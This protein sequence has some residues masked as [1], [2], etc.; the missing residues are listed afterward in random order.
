MAMTAYG[1][2]CTQFYDL[3]KPQAPELA[4]EW[5]SQRLQGAGRVLEP[6]CGS[7]RF[8]VPLVSRGL[9]VD[10]VDPSEPML[11]ACRAKAASA[12]IAVV[13][14]WGTWDPSSAE[15]WPD[16]NYPQPPRIR[17]WQ[18]ALEHL[19]LAGPAPVPASPDAVPPAREAVEPYGAAFIPSS[20]FCLL[21]NA[22]AH[23]GL[24]RL[25]AHL[26]ARA[27]LLIEFEVPHG[28]DHWPGGNSR[29]VTAGSRQIRLVSRVE[30]NAG[31]QVET[32]YNQYELKES[33][34]VVQTENEVLR[35]RSYAPDE[36]RLLLAGAGFTEIEVEH[37]EF[38]WVV[39]ANAG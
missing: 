8:L 29:T 12:R 36:M 7:G 30:Y 5:Y 20:S 15:D 32:H 16:G 34:R 31:V 1:D 11:R 19:D 9:L 24:R 13:S 10:G 21:D 33:G 28:P 14:P 37:P 38:G 18:Q 39:I 22:A 26:A 25:R 23:Q 35:L 3:D 27:L 2:L 6:M 4:L 17:L